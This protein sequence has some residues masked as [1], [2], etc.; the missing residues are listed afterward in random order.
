MRIDWFEQRDSTQGVEALAG[1][2]AF[3]S[4]LTLE[5]HAVMR[6]LGR[7][8]R[9]L[10]KTLLFLL[11]TLGGAFIWLL[12]AACLTFSASMQRRWRGLAFRSWAQA[13]VRL[14]GLRLTVRGA[15]PVA[16]FLLVANHLSYVDVIV[17]AAQFDC[18]FVAKSEI[19]RWPLLGWL[20]RR[21]HTIFIDRQRKRDL[22]RVNALLAE[23]LAAG[24]NIVLFP[25]GTTTAGETLLPFKAGLLEPAVRMGR[26]VSYASLSYR[27]PADE[28][29]AAEAVC[30]WGEMEF[31]PHLR[32]LFALA[33]FDGELVFGAAPL[34]ASSRKVLATRL[35]AAVAHDLAHVHQRETK[36]I[37]GELCCAEHRQQRRLI[38]SEEK[39]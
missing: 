22:L 10:T 24:E 19:A 18:V 26:H 34:F 32:K 27:T 17:L 2:R 21:M 7:R 37:A 39:A 35:H 29:P 14:F 38:E 3:Q 6:Q 33:G 28:A 12:G 8:L 25:E 36:M 31:M 30:W 20:S 11:L 1:V 15:P 16:P 4:G 5:P 13:M 9:V 23:R